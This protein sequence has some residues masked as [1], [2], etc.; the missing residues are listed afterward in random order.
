MV[1]AWN[2]QGNGYLFITNAGP[3][4][5]TTD[6]RKEITYTYPP[7]SEKDLHILGHNP[8]NKDDAET[9]PL[10]YSGQVFR[11]SY[12]EWGSF[13]IHILRCKRSHTF[14]VCKN[15]LERVAKVANTV[16]GIVPMVAIGR[17]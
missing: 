5:E 10:D 17:K 11:Y 14:F 6:W 13:V 15:P 2:S 12:I 16:L 8:R 1:A 3:A 7:L 4:D 9:N